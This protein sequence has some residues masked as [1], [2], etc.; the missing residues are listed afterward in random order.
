[1]KRNDMKPDLLD[2]VYVAA[3]AAIVLLL[4]TCHGAG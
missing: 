1:M 4:V 3:I 2:V